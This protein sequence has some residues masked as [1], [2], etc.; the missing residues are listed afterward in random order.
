MS[1]VHVIGAA[2][3][4]AGEFIRLL[5]EH[6]GFE[7]GHLESQ[8]SQGQSL[9][10]VFP[11]LR[12]EKAHFAGAG[13]VAAD[14]REGDF[15]AY[16][17]SHG[18]AKEHAAGLI[19]KGA[20]VIDFSP[21]FRIADGTHDAVYGFPERYRDQIARAKLVANPGCYPTSILLGALPLAHLDATPQHLIIDAKSGITGSGRNPATGSLFA[22]VDGDVRTYG[23]GG[24]RHEPE[25]KQELVNIGMLAPFVFTPQVVP[26]RR[27]MLACLYVVYPQP[28]SQEELDAAFARE[29][30]GNPFVRV[31][32]ANMAPNL[33]GIC[34]TNDAE[35]TVHARG[36]VARILVGIDNLGKGAAAQAVQNLNIMAGIA[37][38]TG[39]ENRALA[40]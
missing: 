39:L 4:A 10:E 15:V 33:T 12:R 17:A 34:G 19:A 3:Y 18:V 37:Q 9:G 7:L 16:C 29:Y 1:R 8:S 26:L 2:G 38:E 40:I 22:E 23:F 21:D 25:M 27:G 14:V 35:I 36:N 11:H 13:A 6:P 30:N 32:D 28:V 20:R 5:S 31:L 24:H